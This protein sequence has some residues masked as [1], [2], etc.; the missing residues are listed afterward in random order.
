MTESLLALS[1]AIR[2]QHDLLTE[3]W[4]ARPFGSAGGDTSL[5]AVAVGVPRWQV[6]KRMEKPQLQG[7]QIY[8]GRKGELKTSS[9]HDISA[10]TYLSEQLHVLV[11]QGQHIVEDHWASGDERLRRLMWGASGAA[12]RFEDREPSETA[13]QL[14]LQLSQARPLS[15]Y[16]K[17]SSPPD[18]DPETQD[19]FAVVDEWPSRV[20]PETE[21]P[22]NFT[23]AVGVLNQVRQMATDMGYEVPSP[24]V[25]DNARQVLAR[26]CDKDSRE[27]YVYPMPYGGISIDAATPPRTRVIIICG[28]DGTAQG[29][30]GREMD[31]KS[32]D[33]GDVGE[34]PD[35]FILDA[36]AD[37][38][39]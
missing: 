6:A 38:P 18:T 5:F 12:Y 4:R 8:A 31:V 20:K 10:T 30:V 19:A 9:R 16:F 27:F 24:K 1:P 26:V 33:Y 36:L 35:S 32:R 14:E 23:T 2:S 22:A 17:F 28:P 15:T 29:L 7:R 3:K 39:V 21:E 11:G 34:V 25:I 13:K 37:L